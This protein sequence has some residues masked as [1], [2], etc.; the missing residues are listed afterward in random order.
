MRLTDSIDGQVE[1][2][3]D[4]VEDDGKSLVTAAESKVWVFSCYWPVRYMILGKITNRGSKYAD[5]TLTGSDIN[6]YV[7]KY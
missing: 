7:I 2:A 5:Q 6:D 1:L 3:Y 4:N